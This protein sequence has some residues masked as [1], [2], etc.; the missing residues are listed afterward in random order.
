[1]QIRVTGQLS[2][3]VKCTYKGGIW[4]RALIRVKIKFKSGGLSAVA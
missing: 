2:K 3:D 4:N 1:M